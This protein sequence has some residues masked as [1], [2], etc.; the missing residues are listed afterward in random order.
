[1]TSDDIFAQAAQRGLRM[2]ILIQLGESS[3][4]A[5]FTS[6]HL[7][8]QDAFRY[9]YG[10]TA[11]VALAEALARHDAPAIALKADAPDDLFAGL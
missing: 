10:A 11:A 1:M 4:Q 9:G 2:Q 8:G 6:P 3:W 5:C 7:T